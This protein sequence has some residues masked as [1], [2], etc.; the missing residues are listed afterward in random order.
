MG[1][2]VCVCARAAS[3]SASASATL[4]I[5]NNTTV[6]LD[7]LRGRKEALSMCTSW[8]LVFKPV[9]RS[10]WNTVARAFCLVSAPQAQKNRSFKTGNSKPRRML[11]KTW[12]AP[13]LR[14]RQKL[15]KSYD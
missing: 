10:M 11:H 5:E 3:A 8:R 7:K 6:T 1:V 14:H 4:L 2:C 12:T 9:S 15:K 13:G